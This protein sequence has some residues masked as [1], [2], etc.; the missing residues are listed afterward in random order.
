MEVSKIKNDNKELVQD[1]KRT[2]VKEKT[3]KSS[4][5]KDPQKLVTKDP[6]L[7]RPIMFSRNTAMFTIPSTI[8]DDA[9]LV[10]LYNE[11]Q[12]GIVSYN[13]ENNSIV[14]FLGYKRPRKQ[15]VIT[16]K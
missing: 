13:K 7:Y 11:S 15:K 10:E 12:G 6:T 8:R 14:I 1:G 4:T 16:K 3:P 9:K 2:L 5:I